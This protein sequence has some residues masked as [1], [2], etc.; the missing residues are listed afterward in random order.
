M[1]DMTTLGALIAGTILA[2][3]LLSCIFEAKK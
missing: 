3:I 1:S 2:L